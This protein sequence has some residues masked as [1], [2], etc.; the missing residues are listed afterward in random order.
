MTKKLQD[1]LSMWLPGREFGSKSECVSRPADRFGATIELRLSRPHEF[2]PDFVLGCQ[3]LLGRMTV[4]RYLKGTGCGLVRTSTTVFQEAQPRTFFIKSLALLYSSPFPLH[5][6]Q[7]P[8][9]LLRLSP[10]LSSKY[11]HST[12]SHVRRKEY[13]PGPYHHPNPK[14]IMACS[15]YQHAN[16]R[17]AIRV[18]PRGREE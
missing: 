8:T 13:P 16:T 10:T 18:G 9:Q 14:A 17:T 3:N 2:E 1:I 6:F 7:N 15:S 5:R 11:T 12:H 4:I